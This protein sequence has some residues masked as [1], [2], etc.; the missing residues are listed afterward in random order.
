MRKSTGK[1]GVLEHDGDTDEFGTG[2]V[3]EFK[4]GEKAIVTAVCKSTYK[5]RSLNGKDKRP[6]MVTAEELAILI[7]G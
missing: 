3:I 5:L 2:D 7:H 1:A 4:T 6:F